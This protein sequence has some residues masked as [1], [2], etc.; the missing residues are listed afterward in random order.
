MACGEFGVGRLPEPKHIYAAILPLLADTTL[1]G[2]H[3]VINAGA[4]HEPWDAVRILSN[5]ASGHLGACLAEYAAMQGA[6]VSLIAGPSVRDVMG[7]IERTN[8]QDAQQML[9]AC[10][11]KAVSATV[12][13]AT[14]AVSDFRFAEP[15]SGKLKRG[16]TT[17]IQVN[18]QANPDIVAHIAAMEKRPTKIIAF[19]AESDEQHM[20]DYAKD[21][22]ERKKVDVII[23]NHAAHMGQDLAGGYWLD[24]NTEQYLPAESKQDFAKIIVDKIIR[25]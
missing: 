25:D 7:N 17:T 5:R 9:Q 6:Q 22:L 21:K 20:L 24:A 4:T 18:M 13:I 11:Q 3:W 8:V 14:A 10:A 12:F 23:A 16:D 19:A 1:Q 2:E 15:V